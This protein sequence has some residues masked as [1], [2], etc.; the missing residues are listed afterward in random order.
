[1]AKNNND[2]TKVQ[3]KPKSVRPKGIMN[4][5]RAQMPVIIIFLIVVFLGMI[6]FEWGMNYSGN[7]Q[8]GMV[9][10]KVNGQE[11]TYNEYKSNLDN[12]I[13]NYIQQNKVKNGNIDDA[14]MKQI[15]DQV[16]NQMVQTILLKQEMEKLSLKIKEFMDVKVCGS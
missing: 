1:M 10:G 3:A 13:Q 14:T 6:I 15:Q 11:I 8:E 2:V 12:A 4:R 9:F 7:S 5:M 16:W